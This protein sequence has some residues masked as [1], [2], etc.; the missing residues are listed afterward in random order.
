LGLDAR[1]QSLGEVRDQSRVEKRRVAG[2]ERAGLGLDRSERGPEPEQGTA[3]RHGV[4]HERDRNRN[5][6]RL[7]GLD[8]LIEKHDVDGE[9]LLER[10]PELRYVLG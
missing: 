5:R 3:V 7:L 2:R 10:Y 1:I 4:G 8:A 9:K 6:N